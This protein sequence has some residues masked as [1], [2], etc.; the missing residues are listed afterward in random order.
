MSPSVPG[1]LG[2]VISIDQC[3]NDHL[4]DFSGGFTAS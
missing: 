2:G 4:E 3:V 1:F